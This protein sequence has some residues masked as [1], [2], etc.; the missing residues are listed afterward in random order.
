M[1]WQ[2][3]NEEV[4]QM[5]KQI[6]VIAAI[7]CLTTVAIAGEQ[8]YQQQMRFKNLDQDKNGYI[9]Q[10]EARDKHRVFYYYP[11]ADKN[12]DGHLDM[13]EFSAFE[14]EVPDYGAK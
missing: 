12:S 3:S 9:S 7:A 13:S 10:N 5:Y 11:K 14:V 6:T 2:T 4:I 1:V 8:E